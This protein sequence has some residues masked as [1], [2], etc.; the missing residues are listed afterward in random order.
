MRIL[1]QALILVGAFFLF[2]SSLGLWRMKDF[3]QR[4]HAPTKAATL[5]LASIFA[6]TVLMLGWGVATKALLAILFI[7]ATA[8]VGAHY[9]ARTAYRSGVTPRREL[10]RDDYAACVKGERD[11]MPRH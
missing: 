2:V 6:A 4:I 3:Y 9:L 7:G 5:G 11:L 10:I 1:E 8:P